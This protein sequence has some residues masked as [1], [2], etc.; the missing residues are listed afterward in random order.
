[1]TGS[2]SD[3]GTPVAPVVGDAVGRRVEVRGVVQGVGFR[4]FV[5]RLAHEL[6]LGGRVRNEAGR[7]DV[8]I[9]GPAGAVDEFVRRLVSDAP[10]LA[11]IES[12][13]VEP[14]PRLGRRT[15]TI[16]ASARDDGERT[17]V[18]PDV[19][20]CDACV[21]ELGDPTDR[22]H[23]HPFIT[24]T[25][26]GPR[27]TIIRDLPYDRPTTTM[28][29][30]EMCPACRAEYEDPHDRRYHAQPVACPDC[31]PR[32]SWWEPAS[33]TAGPGDA[34]MADDDTVIA[35]VQRSLA[36]GRV[37]AIK[38]LGGYHLAVDATDPGAV[39]RL[40]DR[41]RR[42]HKPFAVMVADLAAA[43]RVAHLDDTEVAV[44][45]GPARPI[46]LARA[47]HDS[48]V[49][50]EVAPGD[51][52]VGVMLPYTPLHHLLFRP[53]PG[54]D[55]PVPQVLVMT[56]G[57]LSDEPIAHRDDDALS[58]LSGVADAFCLHD[59]PIHVP[60]DDSV[61]R[62]V[63]GRELPL[64]RSRGHAPLPIALP[65]ETPPV[66]AVG[67]ELKNTFCVASGSRAWLSPHIGD[68]GSVETLRA[69]ETMV[70]SFTSFYGVEPEVVVAD[71]HPGYTTRRWAEQR[72]AEGRRWRLELVRHHHAHLAG[73]LVERGIDP[74][75]PV[76][77][78]AFDGTGLGADDA[79]WGGEVLV[80]DLADAERVAHLAPFA[81][82]GGDA[83]VRNPCRLALSLLRSAGIAWD[84]DL[85]PV[86]ACDE[87]ERRVLHRQLETGT[88]CVPTTSMGRLFDAV[89]SLLGVRHRVTFEAQ[90]A[91][92]LE[93]L[94]TGVEPRPDGPR[95]VVRGGV[96]DHVPLITGLVADLRRGVD[97]A[98][99]AA[100]LH[101]AVVDAIVEV[102]RLQRA[103][104]GLGVVA[105]S[106]GVFQNAVL[107]EAA[108]SALHTAGFEV[109]THRIVPPN[110]GGLALGQVAVAA[111]RHRRRSR[112]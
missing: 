47:R 10:P 108:V 88:A 71:H 75:V 82:P 28:A 1:M 100:D 38:G 48:P 110:D 7:V 13:E 81:L 49:C 23:R 8:E 52:L 79:I 89:A 16:V 4:P 112:R 35:A 18:P 85:A 41:K 73:V 30:F 106:G 33:G 54:H 37:V 31:G 5:H 68:M 101:A 65:L 2:R 98:V 66:L 12:V 32:L 105:L 97:V 87:T 20:V 83:G 9:E 77:G 42:P 36:E 94:A 60:C 61:V 25:D 102:A 78:M 64:R 57:N 90:A 84:D 45:T 46:V 72:R 50:D 91:I 6:G 95:F 99:L 19:A 74:G 69:F 93:V 39:R 3:P 51:P 62:V 43:H 80:A 63:G 44:L 21:D 86:A 22:R 67:A 40:R 11:R 15:F 34:P 55:A 24:C 26:C 14:A 92:E 17:F 56:S 103:E 109:L 104:R 96:V 70:A 59:R 107:V 27:F 29:G 58:R 53:V 76:V 111:A